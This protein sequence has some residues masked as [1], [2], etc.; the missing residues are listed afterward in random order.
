MK[1]IN[2]FENYTDKETFAKIVDYEN[3]AE[4]WDASVAAYCDNNA[5]IAG[6]STCSWIGRPVSGLRQ[7]TK[8]P[9]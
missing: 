6:A 8:S 1:S 2:V 4:M 9:I 3:L 5:I 7:V